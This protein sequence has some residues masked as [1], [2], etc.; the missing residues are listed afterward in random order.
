MDLLG[1]DANKCSRNRSNLL[2]VKTWS[3]QEGTHSLAEGWK[4]RSAVCVL[5]YKRSQILRGVDGLNMLDRSVGFSVCLLSLSYSSLMPNLVRREIKNIPFAGPTSGMKVAQ[6]TLGLLAA[7][8]A[9]CVPP[10]KRCVPM[11]YYLCWGPWLCSWRIFC[12]KLSKEVNEFW[13][14]ERAFDYVPSWPVSH[15]CWLDGL[16]SGK[17]TSV[18]LD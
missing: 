18:L 3:F 16:E 8:G 5:I 9:A 11:G 17:T 13:I 2:S 4:G 7:L 15:M 6:P 14:W 10:E 12:E 1:G